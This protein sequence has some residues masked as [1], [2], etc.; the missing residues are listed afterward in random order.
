MVGDV[1]FDSERV[2]VHMAH[3][4][5]VRKNKQT[6]QHQQKVANKINQQKRWTKQSNEYKTPTTIIH[7][8]CV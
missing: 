8:V 1:C 2:Q 3:K 7:F 5:A 6:K 4:H